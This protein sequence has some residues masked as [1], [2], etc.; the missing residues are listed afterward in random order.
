MREQL[1]ALP[2]ECVTETMR[3]LPV[4]PLAGMPAF[5]RGM[6]VIR[7]HAIPVVDAGA[8]LGSGEASVPGRFVTL[9]VD[10]RQVAL[11]VEQVVGI[12]GLAADSLHDLPLLLSEASSYLVESIGMLD[13]EFL[14]V[15]RT[16]RIIP[17]SVWTS[18]QDAGAP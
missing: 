3:P 7:G 18:L 9:K 11:A 2:L 17:D 16:A 1:C 15:L 5:I 14:L 8:L 10:G 12:R 6:S 13:T 4:T